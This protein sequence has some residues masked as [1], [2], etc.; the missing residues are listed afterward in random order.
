MTILLHGPV[1]AEMLQRECVIKDPEVL[2]AVRWHST[3]NRGLGHVAKIA[4]LADKL[5]HQKTCR[6]PQLEVSDR[7]ARDDLA[8]AILSLLQQNLVAMIEAGQ[9]IHPASV[10]G[11]NELLEL[12]TRV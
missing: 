2:E 12:R 7:L 4:Y 5:D 6:Y 1:G 10:E 9:L 3:F 8:A 11:R